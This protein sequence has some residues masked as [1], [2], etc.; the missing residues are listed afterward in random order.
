[1]CLSHFSRFGDGDGD[2]VSSLFVGGIA[3]TEILRFGQGCSIGRTMELIRT[4]LDATSFSKS[5]LCRDLFAVFPRRKSH[6][7]SFFLPLMP[8]ERMSFE[9]I[10]LGY[11]RSPISP[12]TSA[13][14][15]ATCRNLLSLPALMTSKMPS[16]LEWGGSDARIARTEMTEVLRD[17]GWH[18]ALFANVTVFFVR[19]LRQGA[20]TTNYDTSH[21]TVHGAKPGSAHLTDGLLRHVD[22]WK[23]GHLR[24]EGPVFSLGSL[25]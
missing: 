23:A 25:L 14:H 11:R 9:S 13:M 3:T 2:G 6:G 15:T 12:S 19:G 24:P 17:H 16:R 7:T 5:G 18:T 10:C 4:A 22:K 21:F 20:Q 8:C 1:M